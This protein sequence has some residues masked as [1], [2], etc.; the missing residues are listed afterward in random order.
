MTTGTIHKT[1][2]YGKLEIV[3]YF[4]AIK[5]LIK[6]IGYTHLVTSQAG[7][8]RKGRVK[9]YMAPSLH[10]KGYLGIGKYSPV[11]DRKAYKTWECMLQRCYCPKYK[12]RCTTYKD[13]YVVEEWLNFQN[14]A[15]WFYNISNFSDGLNLDKDLLLQGNKMYAPNTCL[16]VLPSVNTLLIDCKSKRGDYKLGVVYYSGK[17]AAYCRNKENK[18]VNLGRYGTEQEAHEAYCKYKYK[19]IKS[20]AI[21]QD[22]P[23]KQALLDWKIPMF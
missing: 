3:E 19:I 11:L 14:F 21:E 10:A 7:S 9:N 17:Y 22:E 23:L 16:F 15:C 2:T 12:E 13:C 1:N 5:V 4:N 18:K 8:V 6:F 20:V